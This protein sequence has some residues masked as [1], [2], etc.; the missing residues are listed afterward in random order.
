ML[1]FNDF[2]AIMGLANTIM[3]FFNNCFESEGLYIG[4]LRHIH[5]TRMGC[6]ENHSNG[7]KY[8][9]M[10]VACQKFFGVKQLIQLFIWGIDVHSL[11]SCIKDDVLHTSFILGR[12]VQ[13]VILD[14]LAVMF[15]DEKRTKFESKTKY[16]IMLGYVERAMNIW[17]V[18]DPE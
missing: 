1:L 13:W 5:S 6:R 3:Q 16:H 10:R 17:R 14:H 8:C 2:A 4:H 18:W 15:G 12:S 11:Y 9:Y 7:T